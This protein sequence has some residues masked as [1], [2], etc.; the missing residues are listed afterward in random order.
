MTQP[1]SLICCHR[2]F[3]C[4]ASAGPAA[5]EGDCARTGEANIDNAM[6]IKGAR[7]GAVSFMLR[8]TWWFCDY[9]F[10]SFC[11]SDCATVACADFGNAATKSLNDRVA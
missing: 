3:E 11:N 6:K 9:C 2:V 8:T 10:C 5:G 7:W 4:T 1:P